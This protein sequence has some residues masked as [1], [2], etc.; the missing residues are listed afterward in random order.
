MVEVA[1]EDVRSHTVGNEDGRGEPCILA[2]KGN[3]AVVVAYS[4]K[5]YPCGNSRLDGALRAVGG[6]HR[7]ICV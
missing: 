1:L 7:I 3:S 2:Q 6:V 4:E 5:L